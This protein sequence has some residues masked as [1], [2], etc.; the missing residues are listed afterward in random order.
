MTID[1]IIWFVKQAYP[2]IRSWIDFMTWRPQ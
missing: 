2:N 1:F